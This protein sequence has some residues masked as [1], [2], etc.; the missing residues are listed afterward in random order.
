M[1]LQMS[2]EET[3][4]DEFII[5]ESNL[6]VIYVF[7]YYY[8]HFEHWKSFCGKVHIGLAHRYH[9]EQVY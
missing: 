2:E 5:H 6:R 7:T 3:E 9:I 1:E 4:S 8:T